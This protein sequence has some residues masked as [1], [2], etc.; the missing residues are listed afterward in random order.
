LKTNR[1]SA[2]LGSNKGMVLR[3]A[4]NRAV[5]LTG[6]VFYPNELHSQEREK[7]RE[8]IL[9]DVMNGDFKKL[10]TI[11]YYLKRELVAT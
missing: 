4:L 7:E 1:F 5:T 2:E 8:K 3:D 10:S 9:D 6:L 11:L